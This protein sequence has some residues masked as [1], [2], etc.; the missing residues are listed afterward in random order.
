VRAAEQGLGQ[1][2]GA[3]A[4]AAVLQ[5]IL[6][7]DRHRHAAA[8]QDAGGVLQRRQGGSIGVRAGHRMRIHHHDPGA[9]VRRQQRPLG[10]VRHHPRPRC[11]LIHGL[12]DRYGRGRR[13]L[14]PPV[15]DHQ[16]VS[17]NPLPGAGAAKE[18]ESQSLALSQLQKPY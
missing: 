12:H 3:T 18:P 6:P 2:A 17:Q 1:H 11:R 5:G 15:A 13:D 16:R 8:A 10:G 14:L 4:P 9:A 7:G